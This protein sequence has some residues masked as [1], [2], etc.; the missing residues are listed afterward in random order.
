MEKP[1]HGGRRGLSAGQSKL[2]RPA[3]STTGHRATGFA[4]CAGKNSIGPG[5]STSHEPW[6]RVVGGKLLM[7]GFVCTGLFYRIAIGEVSKGRLFA[8]AQRSEVRRRMVSNAPKSTS[9][10]G[11]GGCGGPVFVRK[12]LWQLSCV[13]GVRPHGNSLLERDRMFT[14]SLTGLAAAEA[15]VH[16]DGVEVRCGQS[17][18]RGFVEPS[19]PF[20]GAC[21]PAESGFFSPRLWKELAS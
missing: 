14:S 20:R 3:A 11:S 15:P 1:E 10:S 8:L 19:S 5:G 7:F 12:R 13:L 2:M 6:S 17:S 16:A 9:T 4:S 21:L 18:D